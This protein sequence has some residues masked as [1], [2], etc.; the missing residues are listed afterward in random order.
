MKQKL[1]LQTIFLM[2]VCVYAVNVFAAECPQ[3]FIC[4][5]ASVNV[6]INDTE[7]NKITDP[8]LDW[9]NTIAILIICA[10]VLYLAFKYNKK[11]RDKKKKGF[12]KSR[13]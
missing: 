11:R 4:N 1:F 13:K 7:F 5:D 9:R 3:G 2:A 12:K 8:A 10:I 6:Q